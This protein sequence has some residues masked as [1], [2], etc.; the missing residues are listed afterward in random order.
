MMMK[1]AL[2]IMLCAAAL[3]LAGCGQKETSVT[4]VNALTTVVPTVQTKSSTAV[5][6]FSEATDAPASEFSA[7]EIDLTSMSST[8]VYSYV[9][10]MISTPDD[11]IG[12]RFRIRGI[13]DEQYWDQTNLTY[14]YIVIADATAC[15]AQGLEFVLTDPNVAYPQVGEEFEISGVFGTYEENGTLYIQITANQITRL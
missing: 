7:M 12:Q 5:P 1:K 3:V 4:T 9:F 13:Y 6:I 14:H 8:M 11:F 10:N 2:F 15:C